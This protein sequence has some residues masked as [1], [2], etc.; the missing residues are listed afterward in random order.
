MSQLPE[1]S[2][3]A[4]LQLARRAIDTF[5]RRGEFPS[6]S[7]SDP[8]LARPSGVFVT[9]HR[10]RRLRGCIGQVEPVEP[11]ATAVARCAI[12]AAREDPRFEPVAL[13]E[14][15]EIEI[16][17]SVLSALLAIHPEMI[18]VGRHGLL[19]TRG[20]QRGLLLPQVARERAWDRERFLEETCAKAGL[21]PQAWRDPATLLHAFT[22]EVFSERD[23]ASGLR[24]PAVSGGDLR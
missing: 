13:Q 24:A 11:L 22:A 9:L 4:A 21:E 20:Y 19:V 6:V 18:E 2:R 17:V 3:W 1:A 7:L 12:A 5:L 8:A 23:F 14:L 16:E 15:P 10:H